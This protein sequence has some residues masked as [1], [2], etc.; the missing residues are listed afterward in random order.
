MTEAYHDA[1]A[2]V[3]DLGRPDLFIIFT[4]NE[5]WPEILSSMKPGQQP[6]DI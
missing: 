3:R 2:I 1:M 5:K 4:C 6:S